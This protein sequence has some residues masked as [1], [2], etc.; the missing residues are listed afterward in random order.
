VRSLTKPLC[1][2]HCCSSLL[3]QLDGGVF[4]LA[5]LA[6]QHSQQPSLVSAIAAQA[7]AVGVRLTEASYTVLIQVTAFVYATRSTCSMQCL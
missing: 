2:A 4:S 6:A 7:R 5:M 1:C 3:W